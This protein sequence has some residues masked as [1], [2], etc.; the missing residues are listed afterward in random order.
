[1]TATTLPSTDLTRRWL[2]GYSII[3][4][5]CRPGAGRLKNFHKYKISFS[6]KEVT[7]KA[8]ELTYAAENLNKNS[9]VMI[10]LLKPSFIV[11]LIN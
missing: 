7:L 1:M 5:K 10:S 9:P 6:P 8:I 3:V 11:W 4:D 2:F